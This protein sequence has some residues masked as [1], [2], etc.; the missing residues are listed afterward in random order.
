MV[1]VVNCHKILIII[2]LIELEL[3]VVIL[4]TNDKGKT[5]LTHIKF[6]WQYQF[7]QSYI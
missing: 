7:S 6:C 2:I 1:G 5:V 4:F 3:L